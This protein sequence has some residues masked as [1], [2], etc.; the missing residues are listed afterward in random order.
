VGILL[1]TFGT[2]FAAEGL[3]VSWPLDDAA[4]LVVAGVYVV[5]TQLMVRRLRDGTRRPVAQPASAA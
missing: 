4:L 1:S 5:A 3:D 2:F